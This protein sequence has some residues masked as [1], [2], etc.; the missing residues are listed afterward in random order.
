MKVNSLLHTEIL[1]DSGEYLLYLFLVFATVCSIQEPAH[2]QI[3]FSSTDCFDLDGLN[4][5]PSLI[6]YLW[7]LRTSET[8]HD[9]CLGN[10]IL[11]E[12]FGAVQAL[13]D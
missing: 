12:S 1:W 8:L 7:I 6:T 5:Y 11:Y 4:C 2:D 10:C 9:V 3:P 13:Y